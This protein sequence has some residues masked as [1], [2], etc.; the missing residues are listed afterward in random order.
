MALVDQSA[1]LESLLQRALSYVA[2]NL[3]AVTRRVAAQLTEPDRYRAIGRI[4]AIVA[5]LRTPRSGR[6]RPWVAVTDSV[7]IENWSIQGP[8][9]STIK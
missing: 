5:R 3:T 9:G 7:E 1:D 6:D 8:T 2:A 4:A